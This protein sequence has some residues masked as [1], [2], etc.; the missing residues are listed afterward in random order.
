MAKGLAGR[1]ASV[2]G[3]VEELSKMFG[4]ECTLREVLDKIEEAENMNRM[5]EPR[6]R[7]KRGP[8]KKKVSPVGDVRKKTPASEKKLPAKMT[9]PVKRTA[10][11]G[12]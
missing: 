1:I 12:K 7:R 6:V 9:P 11:L 3:R 2:K 10:P 4:P 5:F 8:N